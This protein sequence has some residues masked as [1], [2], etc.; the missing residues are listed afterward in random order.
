MRFDTGNKPILNGLTSTS[1]DE[2]MLTS[3]YSCNEG[4]SALPQSAK[5]M[6]A[7]VAGEGI[8]LLTS[9]GR[10]VNCVPLDL[11]AVAT[12]DIPIKL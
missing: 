7:L 4:W 6:G 12:F 1:T 5:I 11:S 8:K 9:V 10:P 3:K 2:H